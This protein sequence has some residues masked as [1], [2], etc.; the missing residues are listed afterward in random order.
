M[1]QFVVPTDTMHLNFRNL[2]SRG[3]N[4]HEY[5][6]MVPKDAKVPQWEV[7]ELSATNRNNELSVDMFVHICSWLHSKSQLL[8]G[9]EMW[10]Q[11]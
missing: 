1:R 4:K 3:M 2:T 7:H 5:N 10:M 6:D 9:Q 11:L 8:N